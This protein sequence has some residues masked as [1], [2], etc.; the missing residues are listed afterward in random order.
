MSDVSLNEV[1]EIG[2]EHEVSLIPYQSPKMKERGIIMFGAK[3]ERAA[4]SF[5]EEVQEKLGLNSWARE[6]TSESGNPYLVFVTKTPPPS[7]DLV[8]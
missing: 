6:S 2:A 5:A 1:V 4:K 7:S 8:F 3:R